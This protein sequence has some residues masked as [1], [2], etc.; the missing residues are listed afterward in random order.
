MMKVV[1]DAKE[2][3]MKKRRWNSLEQSDGGEKSEQSFN[4][5]KIFKS[6]SSDG[7]QVTL[8]Q[9]YKICDKEKVNVVEFFYTSVIPFNVIRILAFAKRDMIERYGVG[10][11]PSYH[12]I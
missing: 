4:S 2:V 12:D 3:S 5:S 1:F 10:Y 7:V 8:N 6:K 11:K 9:L